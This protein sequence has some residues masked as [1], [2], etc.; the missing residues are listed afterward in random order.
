MTSDSNHRLHTVVISAAAA[1]LSPQ[2]P[3]LTLFLVIVLFSSR[4]SVA[5]T[6]PVVPRGESAVQ[7]SN[8]LLLLAPGSER[9]QA[10]L[11]KREIFLP[12]RSNRL[13]AITGKFLDYRGVLVRLH[14]SS[15]NPV[16]L[17]N[18][19][20][21]AKYGGLPASAAIPVSSL[22]WTVRAALAL[23]WSFND[24]RA[25]EAQLTIFSIGR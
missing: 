7:R 9:L 2:M 11:R 17:F 19:F 1:V 24:P 10:I 14:K 25:H 8:E 13:D 20:A 16:H 3:K 15:Y 23:P 6:D 22:P 21:P 4:A 18:P 12:S 5:Q